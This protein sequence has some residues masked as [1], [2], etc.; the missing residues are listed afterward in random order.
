MSKQLAKQFQDIITTTKRDHEATNKN[1]EMEREANKELHSTVQSMN[2][3]IDE[4]D[5]N[6][7]A[8]RKELSQKKLQLQQ[9]QQE[10]S[11]MTLEVE[12]LQASADSFKRELGRYE[13]DM[14]CLEDELAK[15][16]VVSFETKQ[17][18]GA[19]EKEANSNK[20]TVEELRS[21][22]TSTDA[23]IERITKASTASTAENLDFRTKLMS[24]N[25][26]LAEKKAILQ[27]K[28]EQTV[29]LKKERYTLQSEVSEMKRELLSLKSIKSKLESDIKLKS[30]ELEMDEK[31]ISDV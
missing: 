28:E 8:T 11:S 31:R 1:L 20:L 24:T 9:A 7:A 26:Q 21:K 14:R 2:K 16:K 19:A 10:K 30:T 18:L 5:A 23:E 17:K 27:L 22:L 12:Q 29:T 4:N 6:F 15:V 25:T 3:K 13:T